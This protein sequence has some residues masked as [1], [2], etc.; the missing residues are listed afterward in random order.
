MVFSQ[1]F[2]SIIKISFSQ[3]DRILILM[4]K[5]TK[6]F[7]IGKIHF[8]THLNA[9]AS[10]TK[11]ISFILFKTVKNNINDIDQD[12]VFKKNLAHNCKLGMKNIKIMK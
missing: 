7:E 4:I 5:R 6:V 1:M 8:Q 10:L 2:F 3:L 9:C 12:I 11:K